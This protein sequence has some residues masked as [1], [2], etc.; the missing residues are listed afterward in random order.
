MNAHLFEKELAYYLAN[1]ARFLEAAP[2]KVVLIKG[3][4]DYGFF[5]TDEAAYDAGVQ[6]FGDEPFFI[7]D[8]LEDDANNNYPAHL[9]GRI[10]VGC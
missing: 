2:G 4:Q 1:K 3:K 7:Q 6:L 8:I 9:L 10:H 5:D